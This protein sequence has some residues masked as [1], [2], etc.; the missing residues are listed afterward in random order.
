MGVLLL[1]YKGYKTGLPCSECELTM[2]AVLPRGWSM[3]NRLSKI[4]TRTGDDGT[5]G[6]GDGLRVAKDSPRVECM[7]VVDEL[8]S[9]IGVMLTCDIPT[10][11]REIFATIQH[12]LFDLGGEL[13]MPGYTFI[14][15]ADVTW[16]ESVLDQYNDPLPPLKNFILPGGTSAG[17]HCHL[18]R[19]ICRRAERLLVHMNQTDPVNAP[20]RHYVNRLSDWLF[21]C[22]RVL[23]RLDG[24]DHEVLWQPKSTGP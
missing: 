16:L 13:A 8:N 12:R 10:D 11:L 5:T 6:L 21:V 14:D 20:M 15:E 23:N 22:A 17:A 1:L 4:Y 7:G 18:A 24:K 2:S 9:V 19:S 3:G